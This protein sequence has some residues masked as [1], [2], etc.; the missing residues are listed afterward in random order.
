MRKVFLLCFVL[1]LFL[2]GCSSNSTTISYVQAKEKII[3]GGAILIDVR[4][5]EEYDTS[6]ID[7]ASL[8]T[9]DNINEDTVTSIVYNKNKPIIVYCQ[10]GKRSAQALNILKNL[11]YKEVYDL[12]AMSNWKE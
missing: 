8:L 7:G 10:S 3:N 1:V 6:H 9:L 12:G 5:Q 11:G 4:T 2:V